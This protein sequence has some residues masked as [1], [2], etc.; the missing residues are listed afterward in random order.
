MPVSPVRSIVA[1]PRTWVQQTVGHASLV[2]PSRTAGEAVDRS[3]R[4]LP[5]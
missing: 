3:S 1:H 4:H 2:T 5:A